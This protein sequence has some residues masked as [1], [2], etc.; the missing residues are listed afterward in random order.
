MRPQVWLLT[1]TMFSL[2]FVASSAEL[3]AVQLASTLTP[4]R[5]AELATKTL[6]TWRADELDRIARADDFHVA[7]YRDNHVSLAAPTWTWS[8]A[9]EGELYAR[10]YNGVRS[11]WYRSAIRERAGQ[12]SAAGLKKLVAFEPVQGAINEKIDS[13]YRVK[14]RGSKY[15]EAMLSARASAATLK[16][17]PAE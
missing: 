17:R 2:A 8:V 13:A 15:L 10:A 7:P 16:I 1:T 5:G 6:P 9:V 3:D 11:G 12:I 14:Y 4:A